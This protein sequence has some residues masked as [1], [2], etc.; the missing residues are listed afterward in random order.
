[1]KEF[2]KCRK[3]KLIFLKFNFLFKFSNTMVLNR[4]ASLL[5]QQNIKKNNIYSGKLD[6]EERMDLLID[7]NDQII[8]KL[9]N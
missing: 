6:D 1:M 7:S 9:V 4:I 5:K 3:K 8:E 2:L